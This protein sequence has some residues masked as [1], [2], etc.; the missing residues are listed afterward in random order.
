M[1]GKFNVEVHLLLG[2]REKCDIE[3]AGKC[4]IFSGTVRIVHPKLKYK[5]NNYPI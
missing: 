4:C 1:Y 2:E 5:V 3:G